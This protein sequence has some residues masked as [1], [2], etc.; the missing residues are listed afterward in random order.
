MSEYTTEQLA[1]ELVIR[2]NC[3]SPEHIERIRAGSFDDSYGFQIA[4]AAIIETTEAA[5]KFIEDV[6]SISGIAA[7]ALRNFE[8]LK[9]IDRLEGEVG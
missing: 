7:T 5:A 1:R 2:Q 4:L 8:H 9:D 3:W 6:P